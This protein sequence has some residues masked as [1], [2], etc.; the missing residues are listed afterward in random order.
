MDLREK[1]LYHQLHPLKLA[2]DISVTPLFLYYLWEHHVAPALL[3][4]FVPPVAVSL[5]MLKWTPDLEKLKQSSFGHYIERYMTP[6]I[7]MIRFLTLVLMA[8]GAWDHSGRFI[9]F[10]LVILVLAWCHGLLPVG[11]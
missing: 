4:G 6:F 5:A 3:I 2:T 7:Q 11:V 8:Y 9:A 1:V 10:G